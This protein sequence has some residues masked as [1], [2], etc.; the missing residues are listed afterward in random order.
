ME[1]H[2]KHTVLPNSL[3]RV[4]FEYLLPA[5]QSK[6]LHSKPSCA[7][8]CRT[9]CE[10]CR[11]S[12]ILN[13]YRCHYCDLMSCLSVFVC[14]LPQLIIWRKFHFD[15]DLRTLSPCVHKWQDAYWTRLYSFMYLVLLW[16]VLVSI[17]SHCIV[18]CPCCGCFFPFFSQKQLKKRE[19]E[20]F[21]KQSRWQYN[22]MWRFVMTC[23][24]FFRSIFFC[25]F[26]LVSMKFKLTATGIFTVRYHKCISFQS[27]NLNNFGIVLVF[28][29]ANVCIRVAV[30]RNMVEN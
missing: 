7:V 5:Q 16:N 22:A 13:V 3:K 18:F 6:A 11:L 24:F 21:K 2:S 9:E 25:L 29:I 8:P 19:N 14:V 23:I 1:L 26:S 15:N 10:Y 28:S 27:L 17:A 30:N 4:E 20:I 12:S